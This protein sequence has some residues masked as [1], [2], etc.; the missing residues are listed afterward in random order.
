MTRN[1]AG[2]HL[3][4]GTFDLKLVSRRILKLAEIAVLDHLE[5]VAR[6]QAGGIA[7][8]SCDNRNAGI[9]SASGSDPA[10]AIH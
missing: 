5:S 10:D 1:T 8:G 9:A 4:A 6:S 3:H 2:I 7:H